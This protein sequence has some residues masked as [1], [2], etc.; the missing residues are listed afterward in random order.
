MGFKRSLA[1]AALVAAYLLVT[2]ALSQNTNQSCSALPLRGDVLYQFNQTDQWIE[3][4]AMRRNGDMLFTLA[5]PKAQIYLMKNPAGRSGTPN[6]TLLHDFSSTIPTPSNASMSG[7]PTVLLG[8]AQP[9]PDVFITAG[10]MLT[11]RRTTVPNTWSVFE[12]AFLN[13]TDSVAARTVVD[14]PNAEFPNGMVA[15]V[16]PFGNSS[17]IN[18]NYS[19]V[20]LV[21][22]STRGLVYRVDTQNNSVTTAMQLPEM[23]PR[24]DG[25][26]PFGIN[27]MKMRGDTLYFANSNDR[28]FY[29]VRVSED[30]RGVAPNATVQKVGSADREAIYIDDFDVEPD[31]T[32]WAAAGFDNKL[33]VIDPGTKQAVVAA[34]SN[35]SLTVGGPTATLLG[36]NGTGNGTNVLYVVTA[37]AQGDPVNGTATEPGKVMRFDI[38]SFAVC[39]T[40]RKSVDVA[41]GSFIGRTVRFVQRALNW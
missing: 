34:G 31:G 10:G 3:N 24:S 14:L 17:S 33:L 25:Q 26:P 6:V 4:V 20:V 19:S 2:P 35:T 38:S 1:P 22:D 16:D 28:A 8:I 5:G 37:G 15:A 39:K 29:T 23:A 7:G 30:A 32:I 11:Q 21:G 41:S 27:G 36:R 40:G 9:R 18:T 12:L 13:Q